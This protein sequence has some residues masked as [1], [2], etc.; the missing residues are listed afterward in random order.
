MNLKSIKSKILERKK[1]ER[2]EALFL[3]D[4]P[5]DE[6]CQSA[7]EIRKKF[8][9]NNLDMC[10]VI[11]E[12]SGKCS[13]DCKFCAQSAH[14][15]GVV[16]SHSLFSTDILLK[17]AEYNYNKGV[18]TY[19][20][21]T[22][23]RKLQKDEILEVSESIKILNDKIKMKYCASFGLLEEEEL[24]I[25]KNAGIK[26]IHNNLET[27]E[28]FFPSLCTTHTFSDKVKTIKAAQKIG[29]EVCSGGIFG[30]GESM[31]DRIDL[32]FSLSQ[33]EI[34][35]IPINFL[36]PIKGTP[37]EDYKVIPKE[38]ALRIIAIF[39]FINPDSFIKLS[40][41]RAL[42]K[43]DKEMLQSGANAVITGDLLTTTGTKII[44]D[45]KLITELGYIVQGGF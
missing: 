34:K 43:G 41:G 26:K 11:D 33:L 24:Q 1:I 23:G 37:F 40:G 14:Y 38:D 42:V 16:E 3:I 32:A 5:L 20:L 39:R 21:V 22:A 18:P 15:N 9:G 28:G 19:G 45:I 13:E 2:N 25:L 12:K 30:V 7:D 6:L 31:E 8:C 27:S 44:D 17:D 36:N 10:T 4:A 35:S 29:L